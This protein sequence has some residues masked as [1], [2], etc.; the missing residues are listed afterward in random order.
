MVWVCTGKHSDYCGDITDS[1]AFGLSGGMLHVFSMRNLSERTLVP[2]IWR[3]NKRISLRERFI[4]HAR[5]A[6]SERINADASDPSRTR[7]CRL[8]E[9][10]HLLDSAWL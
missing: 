5:I 8:P 10:A 6:L 3:E 7:V 1:L 4:A 2:E 9:H